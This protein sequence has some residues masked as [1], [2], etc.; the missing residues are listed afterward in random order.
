MD[1]CAFPSVTIFFIFYDAHFYKCTLLHC[2][3]ILYPAVGCGTAG[4]FPCPYKISSLNSTAFY[5]IDF[6]SP[7]VGMT[8]CLIQTYLYTKI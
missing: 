8:L 3:N 5:V 7:Y 4:F 6:V 1:F 2:N